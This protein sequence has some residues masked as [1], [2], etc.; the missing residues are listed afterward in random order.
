MNKHKLNIVFYVPGMPFDGD[1]LKKDALGGSETAGLCVARE[2]AKRGHHITMFCNIGKPG[3]F[4][5]VDYLPLSLFQSFI[6]Y[7]LADVLIVERVPQ[8]FT[9][10][11]KTKINM[12]WNHDLA[13]KRQRQVFRG[14]LWNVDEV[15]GLS[16]FHIKQM[17][18]IYAVPKNVFWKSRNGIDTW[19]IKKAR[20]SAKP[21]LPKRLIYTSRPERG[22]DL[23]LDTVMPKIWSRDPD[24]ELVI[25]G[26]EF[27][28]K[29][30]VGFYDM[31]KGKV[32]AYKEQGRRIQWGPGLTKPELYKQYCEAS[33]YVYPSDFDEISC[34]TA[35]ESMACGLPFIGF[36]KGALKETLNPD[37]GIL[38]EGDARDP[39]LLA[40][41]A[42][43]AYELLNNPERLKRMSDTG[44]EYSDKLDWAGVAEQWESHFYDMFKDRSQNKEAIAGQFYRDEDIEVLKKIDLPNWKE[45]VKKE[46]SFIDN[47]EQLKKHYLDQGKN[48]YEQYKGQP[49]KLQYYER[50]LTALEI[51]K[52]KSP[53]T[54]LDFA[55]GIG[56]EAVLFSDTFPEAKIVSVNISPD[57]IKLGRLLAGREGKNPGNIT[58]VEML[59]SDSRKYSIVWAGEYL[60]HCKDV[61]KEIDRLEGYC[62]EDGTMIFSVPFGPW[63]DCPGN[64]YRG[65]MHNFD[66]T[67]L[68]ALFSEKEKL[69]IKVI[70]GG[71][72]KY[73]KETLGWHLISYT[74]KSKNKTGSL[75]YTQKLDIQSPRQTLSTCMIIG[76]EQEGLLHRALKS[77]YA[78]SDEII[79]CDCGMSKNTLEI[80]NNDD[81]KDKTRIIKGKNPNDIGFDEARNIS[82]KAAKYDWILWLDSDEELLLPINLYKYL[83]PNYYSGYSIKQHHFSARPP[84]AFKPDLPVRLFRNNKSIKFFGVCHEHPEV[85][86]NK[87]VGESTVL[88]DVEI[89]HDGYMTEE[90]RRVRFDRNIILVKRDRKKYPERLLGKFLWMRDQ[91]HLSRYTL[92][93]NGRQVTSEIVNW[94]ED[95]IKTY[96]NEFLGQKS[97]FANDGLAY[98][99][100]ALSIL[101]KGL[102]FN[103]NVGLRYSGA[104][105]SQESFEG[106]FVN[107]EDFLKYV[108]SKTES[109]SEPYEGRYI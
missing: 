102:T 101:N 77:V 63:G 25:A 54:I 91:I 21:R 94:C 51:M 50:V 86:L 22:L 84:G 35:M 73:N 32:K 23:L 39:K 53:K 106:N 104:D 85:G 95:V 89:A 82:I 15:I 83:R 107:K 96:Q 16:D 52:K 19:M 70:G 5:N 80:V 88:S 29:E 68:R 109:L 56:N 46:Y 67:E 24:V 64:E 98:Y 7:T 65:H 57:E 55:G 43:T 60:E 4:Q 49:I 103:C 71:M 58:W 97:M 31:L 36:N 76:G 20:E 87:G 99:S 78:V 75:D 47:A 92:E 26:Y 44:V 45:K 105:P 14:S 9:L 59:S 74:K 18:E 17:S 13:T 1:S 72:N 6:S 10:P 69:S 27:I 93:K 2:M 40:G 8:V 3:T 100:E 108:K 28:T 48:S 90:S 66:Q 61:K 38:V 37:A 12:L 30:M 11:M 62:A 42:D 41:F 81:Y 79:I 34:I 33:L